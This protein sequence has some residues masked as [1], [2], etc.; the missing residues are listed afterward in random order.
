MQEQKKGLWAIITPVKRYI[1]VAMLLAAL[2]AVVSVMGFV[3][4]AYVIGLIEDEAITLLGVELDF[5]GALFLLACLTVFSFLIRYYSFVVSHLG[6]FRLE[7]ILRTRITAHLAQ[8]P[9]GHIITLGTGAIKKVLLEDVKN[10]HAFVADTTPMIG[11][12]VV[13]PSASLVALFFID[14]RLAL[15]ALG[16]LVAGALV[17][18]FVMKDSVTYRERYEQSQTEINKAVIEFV[19]AMPVVRTFD[20]GS[21]SFKRFTDALMRYNINLKAWIALTSV[22]AKIAMAILSPMPTLL[23]V[24]IVGVVFVSS[25][26]L[27][28]SP[29]VAALL[30]S[31]G[32]ADAL[33]PLMWMNNFVKKSQAAALRIQEIMDIATLPPGSKKVAL[34]TTD[35]VFNEVAFAYEERTQYALEGISFEVKEKTVTALVGP[36]GAGKSTVAKLIPRFWDVSKGAITIGGVDIRAMD[37][38]ML[39]DTVSFVFQDTFLFNDTLAANIKMANPNAT[40]A[41]MIEAAKAAQIHGFIMGLPEGYETMAGDRGTSLSGGQKQRITIARA[42][43]RNAPIVVLDEATAFADPE[44]EEEIIKA[45]AHL[46]QHKT[47]I[48]IAHRLST[49]RHV[50]QIIVFDQGQIKEKGKHEELLASQ[51]LYASLW[52]NYEKAQAWDLHH[53]EGLHEN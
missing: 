49:I 40:D 41:Q 1:Y 29:F 34:S 36:S 37:P 3:F 18:Y 23:F 51:G 14:W 5:K 24:S 33:M 25:G 16:V 19:Q 20:D 32:M 44:N 42:I 50:D 11:K 52:R 47:V 10:L 30:V 48:V 12:A 39:M 9:L 28:F 46:M 17:M 22:P 8:I 45:L 27:G 43:L 4:L 53:G 38:E 21:T 35:I 15:V 2:G 7:Q 31:T 6:A 13:A 26:S